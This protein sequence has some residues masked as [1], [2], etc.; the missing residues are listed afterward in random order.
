MF[1]DVTKDDYA[2]RAIEWAKENGIIA[3]FPDGTFRGSE[4]VTRQQMALLLYKQSLRDGTFTDILPDILKSVVLV[5]VGAGLG[6]GVCFKTNGPNSYILTN[7]HVVNAGSA[8]TIIKDGC[9]NMIANLVKKDNNIDLAILKVYN[10]IYPPCTIAATP[11]A[12]GQPICVCGSPS[13]LS[14]S[15]SVGLVSHIN[16]NDGIWF[17]TDAHI[18]PGNSGGGIFNESGELVGIS[19]AKMSD[20]LIDG[21]GF[22]IKLELVKTFIQGV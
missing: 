6:S 9:P 2:Y 3:G 20:P 11:A 18:N 19:V 15:V 14:D 10:R 8:Y 17:Q 21:V 4:P 5:N 1:T 7:A 16:R 13:G 22:G 12:A